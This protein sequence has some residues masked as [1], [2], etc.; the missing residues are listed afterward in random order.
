MPIKPPGPRLGHEVSLEMAQARMKG[1]HKKSLYAAMNLVAY[2]DMMTTI[3]IFLLMTFS[4]SGEILFVS[5]SIVLPGA[6][7]WKDLDQAPVVGVA[8]DVVTLDGK[9]VADA[10]ELTKADTVDWKITDLHDQ[11]VT[12]KNNYKLIHPNEEFKGLCIVQSDRKVPFKVIKKVM[13]S[14][15][16]AGYMNVMFA[17]KPNPKAVV[18]APAE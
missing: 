7:N 13:Y 5:K 6:T 17:V 18:A 3:V 4:A 12:L 11:L 8:A 1:Q 15:A 10:N 14:A 9:P 16:I 2:I